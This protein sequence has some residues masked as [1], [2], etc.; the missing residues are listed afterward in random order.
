MET[1]HGDVCET[2]VEHALGAPEK[3]L[4]EQD[5]R[6]KFES[7]LKTA[8]KTYSDD[9]INEIFHGIMEIETITDIQHLLDLL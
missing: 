5:M 1:V 3:P 7:C 2:V 4:T 6:N 8:A 9:Q